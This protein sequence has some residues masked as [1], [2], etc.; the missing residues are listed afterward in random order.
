ML[1][2]GDLTLRLKTDT[3]FVNPLSATDVTGD[4]VTT[5][6]DALRILNAINSL[7]AGSDGTLP[8]AVSPADLAAG[9]LDVNGDGRVTPSDALKI[10][11]RLAANDAVTQSEPLEP[12]IGA[13]GVG[14]GVFAADPQRQPL[15]SQG[16][17]PSDLAFEDD[18][19][20]WLP[21]GIT[22]V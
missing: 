21:I 11:N 6:R 13:P 19:E 12:P 20:W 5:P 8:T 9:Y 16:S 22:D 15:F 4:G 10:I 18:D 7:A 2:F 14:Q 17:P 3:P 1:R